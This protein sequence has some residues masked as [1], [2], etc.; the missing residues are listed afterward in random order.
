MCAGNLDLQK[1][2]IVFSNLNTQYL[3]YY[4]KVRFPVASKEWEDWKERLAAKEDY[5]NRFGETIRAEGFIFSGN[6]VM[7]TLGPF[8]EEEVDELD[9][10][11]KEAV[12]TEPVRE[13]YLSIIWEEASAYIGGAISVEQCALNIDSRLGIAMNETK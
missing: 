10:I 9:R 11:V 12:Y 4:R 13:E 5:V 1:E 7:T 2:K 3:F 8:N 6:G